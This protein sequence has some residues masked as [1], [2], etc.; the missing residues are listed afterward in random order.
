MYSYLA[1]DTFTRMDKNMKYCDI[2]KRALHSEQPAPAFVVQ[3]SR[4]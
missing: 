4:C 2:S 3:F 1:S